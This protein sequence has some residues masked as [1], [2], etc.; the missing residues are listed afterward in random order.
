[1]I[2]QVDLTGRVALITGASKG[3][4]AAV[5]KAYAK[6]GAHVVLIARNTQ[7]LKKVDDEITA[8][9]GKA[10]LMPLDLMKLDDLSKLG[11]T[12][13]ERFG[14][15]D[16]FVGNA[17]LLGTLGPLTQISDREFQHV[18]DTNL[19]VNF[20]LIKTL[21]PLLQVSDAGRV[22]F[23]ST[24]AGVV[25]GRAYWGTYSFSKAALESMARVY[26]AENEKTNV[27]INI[28]DPG[29]VRTDMRASAKPGEDPMNLPSPDD[30]T[31]AFLDLASPEY[32]Q[33][34]NVIRI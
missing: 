24:G 25:E 2:D 14:Q 8:A 22:I 29:G 16:I 30:I 20:Y 19:S 1:M 4:G 34:G 28:I 23:V 11:P 21:D 6:A 13:Y 32:N 9:G 12:L 3:I 33:Q 17:G 10:T 26:A 27:K 7:K 18:L 5:A 15:L 31:Q